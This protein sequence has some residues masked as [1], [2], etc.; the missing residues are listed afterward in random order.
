[1]SKKLIFMLLLLILGIVVGYVVGVAMTNAAW[2][3]KGCLPS[4]VQPTPGANGQDTG[5]YV[6]GKD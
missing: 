4:G 2:E 3:Q 5:G 1:M 6:A